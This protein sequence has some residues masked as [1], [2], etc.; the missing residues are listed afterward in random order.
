MLGNIGLL[1]RKTVLP[2][3]LLLAWQWL[4]SHG[5]ISP[6]VLAS[7]LDTLAVSVRLLEDGSLIQALAISLQRAAIGLLI[8]VS[9]GLT[10]GVAAGYWRTGEYLIDPNMQMLRTVPFVAAAPLFMAWFGIGETVKI[11]IIAFATLFPIY[12]GTYDGIR[13]QNRRLWEVARATGMRT[14][15]TLQEIIIPG[16]L[17]S[18]LLGLRYALTLSVISLV[19]AEQINV[20]GG[21][22]AMMFEARKFVQTDVMALCLLLYALLG[23]MAN[24][25]ARLLESWLLRW[26]KEVI[27]L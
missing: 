6:G 22:G 14:R 11:A 12:I 2:L 15:E 26:R 18:V 21:I 16:A 24:G 9:I 1:A 7:P 20:N 3:S 27:A 23:V 8:G 19:I 10:L 4:T 17:P 13:Q 5:V 25:L